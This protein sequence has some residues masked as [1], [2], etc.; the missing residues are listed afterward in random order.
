MLS[1]FFHSVFLSVRA[2]IVG[3]M[4]A[5]TVRPEIFP[6]FAR[7][8]VCLLTLCA[9][10]A[11]STIGS[12]ALQ[13][14]LPKI[15]EYYGISGGDLTWIIASGTLT[16]GSFLLLFGSLSDILGRK[17]MLFFSYVWFAIWNL[18][19]GFAKSDVVF[20]IFRGLAGV[21]T[22]GSVPACVGI[23]GSTYQRGT[24]KNKAFAVLGAFQPLGYV[25][26]ILAGGV[27]TQFLSWQSN[28]WFL[29][30][31]YSI[32]AV[33]TWFFVPSD[34][35]LFDYVKQQEMKGNRM[36][37]NLVGDSAGFD[38][39]IFKLLKRVDFVGA[40]LVT[41]GFAL[42]VFSLTTASKLSTG[43]TSAEVLSPLIIGI[44]LIGSFL[45]WQWYLGRLGSKAPVQPLMPLSIWTYPGLVKIMIVVTLGWI[46]FTGILMFFTTLWFQEINHATPLSTTARYLPQV[47]GGLLVNLFA[48]YT[49]HIIPGTLL[50]IVGMASFTG[51][52]LLFALQPAQI[53]YWAMAF[54]SLCLS[55]V[56]ADLVYMV[57]NLFVT[58]SVPNN[59]K[60]TAGAVFN[61]VI[62]LANTIGLGAGAAV[63]NSVANKGLKIGESTE[64]F[65][66]R[67]YQSAFWLATGVT[68]VGTIICFFIKI[69]RQGHEKEED[70]ENALELDSKTDEKH[71][72]ATDLRLDGE[73]GSVA[74][75]KETV[76]SPSFMQ[77]TMS[78]DIDEKN[79]EIKTSDNG[80]AVNIDVEKAAL[81]VDDES[82]ITKASGGDEDEISVVKVGQEVEPQSPATPV[83]V[84]TH[85]NEEG[86]KK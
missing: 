1:S 81:K 54:P 4:S 76:S 46:N 70:N 36:S 27:T 71:D 26:G 35:A 78:L 80:S 58:E 44:F 22:A 47:F 25:I 60:S 69:G 21:G 49:L 11:T 53:T 45:V 9:S 50:L 10:V 6:S 63:A 14:A 48:G 68:A 65:L 31:L 13:V 74:L 67:S 29:A 82:S 51:S 66:V 59:L 41:A 16:A 77:S 3:K 38:Q 56:G 52:A 55:V 8:A 24:R 75:K 12:G 57:S 73:L 42:F 85:D 39:S 17:R 18:A 5:G 61:T 62:A 34:Q 15:G 43:W 86:C 79:S 28:L 64:D 32:L 19:A 72:A 23:L 84:V 2:F 33:L 30:I 83:I 20:D 40:G 7:E 37:V